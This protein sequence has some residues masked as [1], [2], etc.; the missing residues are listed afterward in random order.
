MRRRQVPQC[1]Q[2]LRAGRWGW[3]WEDLQAAVGKV[4]TAV[5]RAL[6]YAGA[7][8]A[9]ENGAGNGS[10]SSSCQ[11]VGGVWGDD[12]GGVGDPTPPSARGLAI[13]G[14]V[15]ALDDVMAMETAVR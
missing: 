15:A 3:E 12:A 7:A 11:R 5:V 10:S 1:Q 14:A 4:A 9:S 6:M 8:L 2:G 13:R